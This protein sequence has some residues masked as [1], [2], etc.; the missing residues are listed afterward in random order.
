MKNW[1]LLATAQNL[2]IPEPE[3]EL[4]IPALDALE[5]AFRP[6]AAT[7]PAET[8]PAVIFRCPPE[9]AK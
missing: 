1:K 3:L 7:I 8:E 9:D 6:L 4:I 5:A 2:E